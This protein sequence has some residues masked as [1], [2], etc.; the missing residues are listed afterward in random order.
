MSS[1]VASGQATGIGL[2]WRTSSSDT[3]LNALTVPACVAAS[4][5]A[6]RRDGD[7][8][9]C[10]VERTAA[11]IT[12]QAAFEKAVPGGADHNQISL[13]VLSKLVMAL[14]GR[15]RTC[16]EQLRVEPDQNVLEHAGPSGLV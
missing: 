3:T 11:V 1:S 12:H 2:Y 13:L 9:R 4:S 8:A 6:V 5:R 14:S 16:D 10:A 7:R 15:T